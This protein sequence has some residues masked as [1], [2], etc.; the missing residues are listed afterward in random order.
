MT[1]SNQTNRYEY[2]GNGVTTAFAFSST[3]LAEGD[4]KVILRVDSTGVETTQ[5]LTTHY[6]VSGGDGA[7]GTVT[8]L[9]APASGETLIIYNDPDITQ[10]VDL[11]ENNATS[12]EV[13]E[14][15]LDRTAYIARR[16]KDRV[17]RAV[18]LSEGFEDSF[19]TTLPAVLTADKTIAINEA[20][21]GLTLG[22]SASDVES[23]GANATAAAAS[24]AAAAASAS[25]AATSE[26]N[27]ATSEASAAAAA[28]SI[29]A[30]NMAIAASV[31]A[32]A[33]T[34]NL[35]QSDGSTDPTSG[36][37]VKIL[38]RH[39]T[40]A[41]GTPATIDYTVATSIT[42]PSGATLGGADGIERHL[43]LYAIYDGTNRE[44]AISGVDTWDE[45]E[46]H[47]TTILNTSSDDESVLYSTTARTNCA[48]KKI[49]RIT[50]TQA[51]A[52]TWATAPSGL[53]KHPFF[54]KELEFQTPHNNGAD[55]INVG[56]DLTAG[57][58]KLVQADGTDF[59][60]N[61]PGYIKLPSTTDG[62]YLYLKVRE[63]THLFNDDNH[64]SSDIVGEQFGE[65][66]GVVAFERPFYL[67]A[68]NSDN[69]NSGLAF[70]ISPN[71]TFVKSPATANIGYHGN[72]ASTPSD[73]SMFFL[74]D[75]N[76]TA[77]HNA[78]P[79]VRIGGIR[80]SMSASD[81]WNVK[82]LDISEGDGI[83]P[84]PFANKP[85]LADV[86]LEVSSGTAPGFSA[87]T[88][89]Y[90]LKPDGLCM[91]H[92]NLDALVVAGTGS[93]QIQAVLPCPAGLDG[94]VPQFQHVGNARHGGA[95]DVPVYIASATTGSRRFFLA[96][97][98]SG[99]S[100]T[101]FPASDVTHALDEIQ[102][103][104][105]YQAFSRE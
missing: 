49:G 103:Y 11:Q 25:A 90:I 38:M 39:Q 93:A 6:T 96:K 36:S 57:V 91:M 14:R 100:Y 48:I 21:D 16:L 43:F 85:F 29:V 19:D 95:T 83:R 7:N 10:G 62:R 65:K 68:V 23:A 80:M 37:P 70:A 86:Y 102:F 88:S 76:V 42:V 12:E 74:T 82:T 56:M 30:E 60:V 84:D 50:S 73:N 55:V 33:L 28:A 81:D 67:Y 15:A 94:M 45:G 97:G 17:D 34:V 44:L 69:T 31:A 22:P 52:G 20:G 71:P 63:A 64:A 18:Q 3:F 105:N 24:A 53:S 75:T 40:L 41:N 8:M 99:G 59:N 78:K 5:T 26:S 47:N 89:Y 35:K 51:T 104:V 54:E 72:P 13:R 87:G 92:F 2:A 32:S 98:Y 79:C 1:V 9:T 27:A 101:S 77:T 66:T 58:F 4:L 61:Q 46:L